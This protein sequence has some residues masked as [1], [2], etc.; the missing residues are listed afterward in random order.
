MTESWSDDEARQDGDTR[1]KFVKVFEIT[2][3]GS[4]EIGVDSYLARSGLKLAQDFSK[5][6]ESL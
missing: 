4:Y 2:K 1:S 5:Q 6:C 3:T